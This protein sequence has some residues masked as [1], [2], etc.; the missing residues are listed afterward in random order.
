MSIILAIKEV[1]AGRLWKL[2]GL[3]DWPIVSSA[4]MAD[5]DLKTRVQTHR[6]KHPIS[7]YGFYMHMHT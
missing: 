5:P 4:S 7:S 1:E 3:P 6:R 2:A